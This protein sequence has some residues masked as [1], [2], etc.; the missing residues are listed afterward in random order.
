MQQ[1]QQIA[2]MDQKLSI[3]T[4]EVEVLR[5]A[6]QDGAQQAKH[7][8]DSFSNFTEHAWDSFSNLTDGLRQVQQDGCQ[9]AKHWWD[10]VSNFTPTHRFWETVPKFY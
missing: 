4:E 2:A 8:W 1:Q 9:Q 5:Q 6:Q 3:L 7:F 10:S